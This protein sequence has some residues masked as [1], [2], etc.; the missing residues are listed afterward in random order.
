MAVVAHVHAAHAVTAWPTHIVMLGEGPPSLRARI[1][2]DNRTNIYL[3]WP[4]SL[5]ALIHFL[6]IPKAANAGPD[7]WFSSTYLSTKL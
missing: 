4:F 1:S 2:N 5:N 6:L 7:L 3:A